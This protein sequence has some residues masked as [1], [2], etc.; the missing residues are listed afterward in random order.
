[1]WRG[2]MLGLGVRFARVGGLVLSRRIQN[3]LWEGSRDILEAADVV[4]MKHGPYTTQVLPDVFARR[5]VLAPLAS[6]PEIETDDAPLTRSRE[7]A[8]R[9]TLEH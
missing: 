6:S 8:S 5:L 3:R 1:M 9:P 4:D 7:K 2:R